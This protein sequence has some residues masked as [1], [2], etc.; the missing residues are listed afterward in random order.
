MKQCIVYKLLE[1]NLSAKAVTYHID[2]F[3]N[4][5]HPNGV[6]KAR[7]VDAALSSFLAFYENEVH[8]RFDQG[9]TEE[10]RAVAAEL[11]EVCAI[12]LAMKSES[13]VRM[14]FLPRTIEVAHTHIVPS[15]FSPRPLL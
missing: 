9:S 14:C 10:V 2:V 13:G 8:V 11:D 3:L 12:W 1:T 5:N 4:G 6:E 15:V 7:V